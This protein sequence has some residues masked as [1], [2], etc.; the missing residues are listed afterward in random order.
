MATNSSPAVLDVYLLD[1]SATLRASA[2]CA[3]TIERHLTLVERA[4]PRSTTSTEDRVARVL[5]RSDA[6][7]AETR[8]LIENLRVGRGLLRQINGELKKRLAE[9]QGANGDPGCAEPRRETPK[10]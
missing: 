1:L 9:V 2:R 4:A 6:L 10:R 8:D 7:L 3:T 5:A